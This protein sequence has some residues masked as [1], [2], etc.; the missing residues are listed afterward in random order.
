MA[1]DFTADPALPVAG[2]LDEKAL[3]KHWKVAREKTV[4]VNKDFIEK[5]SS[6]RQ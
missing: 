1:V 5:V 6:W 2:L 3:A 4:E